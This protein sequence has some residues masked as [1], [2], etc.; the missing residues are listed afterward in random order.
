MSLHPLIRVG[1]NGRITLYAQNPEMGQ[2]NATNVNI[3]SGLEV[4]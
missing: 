3:S 2:G 1:T 4:I